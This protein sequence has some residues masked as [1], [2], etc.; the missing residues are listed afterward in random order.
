MSTT[1]TTTTTTTTAMTTTARATSRHAARRPPMPKR[2]S[3][4]RRW[5][6][7]IIG[8]VAVASICEIGAGTA[9]YF[10]F[11]TRV[12]GAAWLNGA[13]TGDIPAHLAAVDRG[14]ETSA[15]LVAR[16]PRVVAAH[17]SDE[18][19][20]AI[21]AVMA[22]DL[23]ANHV[24]IAEG[25]DA[26]NASNAPA[27]RAPATEAMVRG[28]VGS[29]VAWCGEAAYAGVSV[30]LADDA[31]RLFYGRRID[32]AFAEQLY[33]LTATEVMLRAKDGRI[34]GTTLRTKDGSGLHIDDSVEGFTI[35]TG[36]LS[37]PYRGLRTAVLA[38]EDWQGRGETE[39]DWLVHRSTLQAVS[40]QPIE[41]ML[42]AP[43]TTLTFGTALAAVLMLVLAMIILAAAF[44]IA[45]IVVRSFTQPVSDIADAAGRVARGASDVRVA[46][47]GDEEIVSLARSFNQM[48]V[49]LNNA[50]LHSVQTE[51]M[52]AIGQLAAGI[53]H[54]MNTPAQY[55]SDN[56]S[57]IR[58]S[59]LE[60]SATLASGEQLQRAHIEALIVDVP[61]CLDDAMEGL[62]R[63]NKIVGAMRTFAHSRDGERE[64]T[65]L[66]ELI[67]T[68]A[69]VARNEWRHVATL[70]VH[71]D[72]D[73]PQV[74]IIRDEIGQVVLNLIV[75][76][77]HAVAERHGED[78]SAGRVD[79]HARRDGDAAVIT[80]S[81]NGVG[82]P[83]A[84]LTRIFEAF[85]TTK[86]VGKGS[87]QGLAIAWAIVVNRH[88]GSIA[89][90]SV[91][92]AGTTFTLRLPMSAH[93]H[94]HAHADADAQAHA[95]ADD[96]SGEPPAMAA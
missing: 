4:R 79:V 41:V 35:T 66:R 42:A 53:A 24:W 18:L 45:R 64:V 30:R 67:E 68:S 71:V 86:P 38:E 75:N 14:F 2:T 49:D 21:A 56:V 39:L 87:G 59:I 26:H 34:I 54:E 31:R 9:L 23:P 32:D 47:R 22:A 29:M 58:E 20:T 33:P 36:T 82:I 91:P 28:H 61:R 17:S 16:D 13:A 10:H 12:T 92:G 6:T 46:E 7:T 78:A 70:G 3:M 50:R 89:V 60:L 51:K 37:E 73:V 74:S 84:N 1:T 19:T 80:V 48:V 27:C 25:A 94:A 69:I 96:V 57:M 72:D 88:G 43:A 77:A 15:R 90:D 95:G 5:L 52:V 8:F 40:L 65:D 85:F 93:A 76:A 83:A 44:P 11:G 81:D 62:R 55:V 63:M